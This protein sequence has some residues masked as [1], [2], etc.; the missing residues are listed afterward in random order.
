MFNREVLIDTWNKNKEH[1]LH[2]SLLYK[3]PGKCSIYYLYHSSIKLLECYILNNPI[4]LIPGES[5][6]NYLA[7]I[8]FENQ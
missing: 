1:S 5:P 7:Y 3:Y 2:G 6:K 8:T 4:N